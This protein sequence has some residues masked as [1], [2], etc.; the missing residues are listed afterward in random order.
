MSKDLLVRMLQEGHS[1]TW[2]SDFRHDDFC[3]I[4]VGLCPYSK[5]L[6]CYSHGHML[7]FQYGLVSDTTIVQGS[8]V[9][10]GYCC[11]QT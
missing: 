3:T 7:V 8:D 1:I 4:V 5:D 6:L 9:S 2:T 11:V 10:V